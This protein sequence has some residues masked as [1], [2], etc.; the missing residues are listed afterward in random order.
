MLPAAAAS[1]S[2]AQPGVASAAVPKPEL[3]GRTLAGQTYDLHNDLGKVVLVFFWSTNCPVC[4]DKMP[5]LRLNFEAWRDKG[6]E[7]LA[8][9]TD[10][11]EAELRAYDA[12][13]G[14]VVAPSQRFRGLWRGD[15]AHRD[16]FGAIAQTPTSFLIDRA[17]RTVKVFRGR[18]EPALWDDIAELVLT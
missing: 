1:V 10:R 5:E 9:S 13:L 15:A 17:G 11:S 3:I 18:I 12:I 4:R 6:F 14:S 2:A 16:N 8:V 7:L